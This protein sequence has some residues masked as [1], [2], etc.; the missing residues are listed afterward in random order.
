[1]GLGKVEAT[2]KLQ[3][4]NKETKEFTYTLLMLVVS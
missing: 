4:N 1:M 2:N 3:L